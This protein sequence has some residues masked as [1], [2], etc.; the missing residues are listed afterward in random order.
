MTGGLIGQQSG[1][2][3]TIDGS[4]KADKPTKVSISIP[5]SGWTDNKRTFTVSGIPSDPTT[6]EVHLA[7][8]GATNVEAAMAC[9]IY[10]AD[11][12]QNSLTLAVNSVPESSFIVY[13]VIQ[14]LD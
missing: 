3:Y 5:T 11:E 8:V 6:Y 1:D 2:T 12:A 7:Q 13:A 14:P 10:I 4:G 9:G